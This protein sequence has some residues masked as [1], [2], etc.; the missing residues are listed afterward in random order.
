[1]VCTPAYVQRVAGAE[2]LKQLKQ[3]E[4]L[5]KKELR[6][7]EGEMREAKRM[8]AELDKLKEK[9]V[10]LQKQMKSVAARA[11]RERDQYNRQLKQVRHQSPAAHHQVRRAI[12]LRRPLSA[13]DST[14]AAGGEARALQG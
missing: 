2:K 9:K 14:R 3:N 4:K 1:M 10:A 13:N 5:Q 8:R 12:G 6:A 7:A 11:K